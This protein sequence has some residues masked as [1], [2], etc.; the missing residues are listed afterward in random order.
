LESNDL[1]AQ[2]TVELCWVSQLYLRTREQE[3][4]SRVTYTLKIIWSPDGKATG[5]KAV[6]VIA[7]MIC[8]I[9]LVS[10]VK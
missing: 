2:L 8:Q 6:S 5:R 10:Q 3:K 1:I 9:I 4:L 7:L